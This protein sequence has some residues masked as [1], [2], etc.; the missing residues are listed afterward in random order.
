MNL[1]TLNQQDGAFSIGIDDRPGRPP[2][3]IAF[4]SVGLQDVWKSDAERLAVA[5]ELVELANRA[6]MTP[7]PH[8]TIIT[9]LD[10]AEVVKALWDASGVSGRTYGGMTAALGALVH[11]GRTMPIER[12]REIVATMTHELGDGTSLS[13]DYIDTKPM[14]CVIYTHTDGSATLNHGAYERDT[15]VNP[16]SVILELRS[17]R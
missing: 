12:A 2:R 17:K 10:V 7:E 13:L 15:G 3:I 11:A 5:T 6:L 1:F 16:R 4:G 14:K 9:G 8:M